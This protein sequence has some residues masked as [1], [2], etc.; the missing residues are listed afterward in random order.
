VLGD[1]KI[2]LQA[3]SP[4]MWQGPRY[5]N[6]TSLAQ[7][8]DTYLTDSRP[9]LLAHA[10]AGNP[11]PRPFP[12]LAPCYTGTNAT[13]TATQQWT[14]AA[15][16]TV[17]SHVDG[18]NCWNVQGGGSRLILWPKGSDANTRFSLGH[19]DGNY[20]TVMT[21]L[22]PDDC[23]V[24][25]STGGELTVASPCSSA[26]PS[27]HVTHGFQYDG[28]RHTIT[29][30]ETAGTGPGPVPMCVTADLN[31]TVA[32]KPHGGG[33]GGKGVCSN[34]CLFNVVDDMTEQNNLFN[35]TEHQDLIVSMTKTLATL[36][37]GFHTNKDKFVNDCP[38]GTKD[39]A[40]WMATH[41]YGGF[42]GPYALTKDGA[43]R[44]TIPAN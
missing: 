42:M 43:A 40:C 26:S 35:A 2:V 17:C 39:C 30:G 19:P 11:P 32:P 37:E 15:D 9:A 23:I 3:T 7:A 18:G 44:P 38:A 10:R 41:K 33:G 21:A 22:S 28:T 31:H 36:R 8:S 16:G 13:I 5:P 29:G 6:S 34:G 12:K 14:W 4:S 25:P 1:Y 24:A 20:G 27:T